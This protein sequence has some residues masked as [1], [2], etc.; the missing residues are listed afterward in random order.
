MTSE[1]RLLLQYRKQLIPTLQKDLGS[2]NPLAVPKVEKV[3]V[4]VGVGKIL[5]D[6]KMLE[7]IKSDLAALTGQRPRETRA[8]KAI[9]GFKIRAGQVVGL[10]VTLRG[11]RMYEF[12]DKLV[13][14]AIPRIRD[15]RGLDPKSFDRNGSYTIGFREHIVF[16]EI[17]ADAVEHTFGLEVTVVTSAKKPEHAYALLKAL[18]FPFKSSV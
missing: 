10:Q 12:L 7:S 11:R 14:T 16:P 15:F 13:N 1:A 18:G 17:P 4:N 6:A 3:V 9:A 2:E 5:K 8:R